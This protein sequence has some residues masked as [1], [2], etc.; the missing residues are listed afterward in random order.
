MSDELKQQITHLEAENLALNS[1]LFAAE[2][3][4][5]S[6]V[7]DEDLAKMLHEAG[8]EAVLSNQVVKKD[9]APL[10]QIKFLEWGQITET[11]REGRRSQVRY[12]KKYLL[13]LLLTDK[14]F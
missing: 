12:L 8:R 5:M 6:N 10:G 9:G 2:R 3:Y 11:A 13:M 1:K 14:P 4:L 7:N